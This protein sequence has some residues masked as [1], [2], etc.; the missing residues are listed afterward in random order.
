MF[1]YTRYEPPCVSQ[2]GSP[3]VVFASTVAT[4]GAVLSTCADPDAAALVPSLSLADT[5]YAFEPSDSGVE[6]V[7]TA[8]WN[9]YA[10]P[11]PHEPHAENP[12]AVSPAVT[13]ERSAVTDETSTPLAASLTFAY[14]R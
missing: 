1:A 8:V 11:G 7:S 4:V 5:E 10:A 6:A 12:A 14:A 3:V 13:A 9:P 2:P